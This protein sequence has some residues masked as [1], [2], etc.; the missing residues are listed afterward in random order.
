MTN[1]TP[2][3]NLSLGTL[4]PKNKTKDRSPDATGTIR[5]KRDLLLALYKKLTESGDDDV[6]ACLAG[7]FYEDANGRYMRVQLS[8]EFQP[9]E[10][11][12]SRPIMNFQ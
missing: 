9:P 8:E 10:Y 1:Q 7:W 12:D 6:V 5:I 3:R 4:R 2:N 11:R